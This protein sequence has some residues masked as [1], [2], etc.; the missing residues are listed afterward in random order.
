MLGDHLY[1][2]KQNYPVNRGAPERTVQLSF[3]RRTLGKKNITILVI[4]RL[5]LK[6]MQEDKLW[7]KIA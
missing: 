1:L 6:I 4:F 5:M 3:L 7:L 2:D